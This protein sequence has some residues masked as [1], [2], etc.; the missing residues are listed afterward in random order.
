MGPA[1]KNT[2]T[3]TDSRY[4]RAVDGDEKVQKGVPGHPQAATRRLLPVQKNLFSL[5]EPA[6]QLGLFRQTGILC[7]DVDR[8]WCTGS[9]IGCNF[10][11]A[12]G[13]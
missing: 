8:T 11:D 10:L 2:I 9:C 6:F 4:Y 12:Y 5:N 13:N 1:N 3:H 7:R